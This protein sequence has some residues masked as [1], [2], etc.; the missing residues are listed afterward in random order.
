MNAALFITLLSVLLSTSVLSQ[1]T[2]PHVLFMGQTL[3]NHSYVDLSLLGSIDDE[4]MQCYTDLTGCCSATQGI[5]RGDW[6]FPDRF[7]VFRSEN[8]GDI[9]RRRSNRHVDL[10]RK[11]ETLSPSGVYYCHIPTNSIHDDNDISIGDRVYIGL[12]ASGGINLYIHALRTLLSYKS[13][14]HNN[15]STL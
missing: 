2:F 8:L 15:C 9:Y 14:I 12:Y 1:T 3:S 7:K 5:H 4:S 11:N 6:Y 13:F 10:Y